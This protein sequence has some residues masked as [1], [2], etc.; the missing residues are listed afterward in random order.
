MSRRVRGNAGLGAGAGKHG[1]LELGDGGV[2]RRGGDGGGDGG[3][4][5][6][7]GWV[8]HFGGVWILDFR[9]GGV[10]VYVYGFDVT[11]MREMM[12]MIEK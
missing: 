3:E 10:D 5:G 7:D 1:L 4:V 11:T 6:G 9:K 8:G 12:M 2:L